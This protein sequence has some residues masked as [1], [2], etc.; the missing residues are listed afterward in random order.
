[1]KSKI[2][3]K[4]AFLITNNM[5]SLNDFGDL[6]DERSP[7]RSLHSDDVPSQHDKN[8]YYVPLINWLMNIQHDTRT[9]RKKA[10]KHQVCV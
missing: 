6:E 2:L 5:N 3:M 1:M 9:S 7:E 8:L 10:V 4:R